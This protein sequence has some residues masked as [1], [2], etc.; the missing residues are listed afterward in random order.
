[1]AICEVQKSPIQGSGLFATE[2]IGEGVTLFQTH[3]RKK[4]GLSCETHTARWHNM[5]PNC[6]Y[7]H[8]KKNANC[9]SKTISTH[10]CPECGHVKQHCEASGPGAKV[11]VT[12]REIQKGE[13]LLVDY[14][15][16]L[17][18]EQPEEGWSE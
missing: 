10:E 11:L 6:Q 5:S 15:K 1:M 3:Y 17:D 9:R 8:S 13:E 14:T 2:D 7:N 18:L 12:L 4:T 16:D